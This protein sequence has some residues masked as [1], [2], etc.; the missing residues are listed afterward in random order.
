LIVNVYRMRSAWQPDLDRPF[1]RFLSRIPEVTVWFWVIKVLSTTVGETFADFLSTTLALGLTLTTAATSAA[2]AAALIAQ[3]RARRYVPGRYWLVVVLIGI[4]GTLL[5]DTMVENLRVPL[6]ATTV[7][8]AAALAGTFAAW[9]AQ[10]RTLSIHSVDT[11][12][13]QAFY[14][15]AVFF[16]FAL[17]RAGGDLATAELGLSYAAL[18]VAAALGIG[19]VALAHRRFGLPPVLAFWL[20]YVLTRPLGASLGDLLAQP[21]AAGGLGLGTVVTSGLFLL[22]IVGVVGYLTHTRRDAPTRTLAT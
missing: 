17:G 16:A 8:F 12:R 21:R 18:A 1:R 19:G 9:Y 6:G 5:T 20:A 14:W 13:R 10:E 7:V 15:L 2:L 11:P 4:A 3:F 22:V